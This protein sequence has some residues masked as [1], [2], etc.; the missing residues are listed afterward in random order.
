MGHQS[1]GENRNKTTVRQKR[2]YTAEETRSRMQRQSGMREGVWEPHL[3]R[4]NNSKT[5]GTH[6]TQ[7]QKMKRPTK[8]SIKNKQRK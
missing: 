4:A 5:Q 6:I 3:I 7:E 8:S 2:F 1:T